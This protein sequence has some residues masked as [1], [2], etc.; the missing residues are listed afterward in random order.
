[1]KLKNLEMLLRYKS[2]Q[3][4]SSSNFQLLVNKLT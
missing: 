3:G 2:N 4:D 1:M